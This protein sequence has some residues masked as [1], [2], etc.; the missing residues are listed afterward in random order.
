MN[1]ALEIFGQLVIAAR[2]LLFVL[3]KLD[4]RLPRLKVVTD[5]LGWLMGGSKERFGGE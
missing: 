1:D 2:A 3:D 5:V 4:D